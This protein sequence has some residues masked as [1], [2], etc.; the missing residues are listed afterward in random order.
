MSASDHDATGVR[1]HTS[2]N[3]VEIKKGF[4]AKTLYLLGKGRVYRLMANRGLDVQASPLVR[5]YLDITIMASRR[6]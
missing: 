4:T 1:L 6:E 5:V 2:A 3:K